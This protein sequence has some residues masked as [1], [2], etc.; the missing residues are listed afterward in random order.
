MNQ[1]TDEKTSPN[2]PGSKVGELV[3]DNSLSEV[4]KVSRWKIVD[5]ELRELDD[6]KTQL[7]LIGDGI[8]YAF[9]THAYQNLEMA[10]NH[11]GVLRKRLIEET[12]IIKVS[13]SELKQ[14][15]PTVHAACTVKY[16]SN[17]FYFLT[18]EGYNRT[19]IEVNTSGMKDR[20]IAARIEH[21]KDEMAFV[22]TKYKQGELSSSGFGIDSFGTSPKEMSSLNGIRIRLQGMLANQRHPSHPDT[23]RRKIEMFRRDHRVL[24]GHD[25]MEEQWRR[26]E[27]EE[28]KI[29]L[30]G[31]VACG[32]Y[33]FA[34][35]HLE[36][37]EQSKDINEFYATCPEL[38]PDHLPDVIETTRQ[39]KLL[40]DGESA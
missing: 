6:G 26:K 19:I 36:P 28:G 37:E 8:P 20:E 9:W 18:D 31:W 7:Y 23:I 22:F 3:S 29:K 5:F 21:R 4:K 32:I 33:S 17:F 11:A 30:T 24:K 12:H 25:K 13:N 39:T 34:R 38:R 40:P 14:F 10:K 27:P 16:K 1:K 15:Y 2:A 35:G